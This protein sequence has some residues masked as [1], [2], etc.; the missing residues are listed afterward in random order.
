MRKLLPKMTT[1]LLAALA[2]VL[3]PLVAC[4]PGYSGPVESITIGSAPLES[5]ALIYI[6]EER[7][8]FA[9]NG[10]DVTVKQYATGAVAHNAL[11]KGEVDLAVPAEYPLVGSAFIKE[12]TGVIATIA[13]S[14]YFSLVGRKDLGV[15]NVADLGGRKIGLVQK[16]IAEFYF[17][18][19]LVLNG[20][21][22]SQVTLVNIDYTQSEEA[23]VSG[24][25][26]AVVS[27]PPYVFATIERLG[28]NAITWQVQSSQALYAIITARNSW[29]A[30]KPE[31]TRRLLKSLARAEEYLSQYPAESKAIVQKRLNLDDAY[32]TAVWGQ[33]DFSLTL[34][35]S[36]VVALEDEA[37][38]MISSNLT[39]ETQVPDFSGYIYED[40]LRAIRPEAVNI[41]R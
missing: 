40:A 29:L 34:G 32:M 35:Q 21:D 19:F 23:I 31:L 26:D 4:S 13:K 18:R 17:G 8:F 10:L 6:A 24:A 7:G 3:A 9:E 1:F 20:I 16:T 36:L 15:A 28:E 30:A 41:I 11:L 33:N 39:G 25:V 38:W 14:Q 12:E 2:A 27:R 22:P 37:R 5:S